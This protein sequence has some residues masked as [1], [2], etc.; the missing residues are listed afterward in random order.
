MEYLTDIKEI[1]EYLASVG[2]NHTYDEYGSIH[3]NSEYYEFSCH[4]VPD[5]TKRYKLLCI[6]HEEYKL[7]DSLLINCQ[8]HD[9]Y[10]ECEY[11]VM[12]SSDIYC[13]IILCFH[14]NLV[15][16]FK[17]INDLIAYIQEYHPECIRQNDI[18]IALK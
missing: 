8:I 11:N 7:L 18:K 17:N 10:K 9:K 4:T 14:N 2:L 3:I 15:N 6:K 1:L 16:K 12:I 5:V 13:G